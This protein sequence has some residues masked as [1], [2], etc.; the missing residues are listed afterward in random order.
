MNVKYLGKFQFS[1]TFLII[2]NEGSHWRGDC[3]GASTETCPHEAEDQHHRLAQQGG[4]GSGSACLLSC[5]KYDYFLFSWLQRSRKCSPQQLS[6]GRSS[7]D[8]WRSSTWPTCQSPQPGRWVLWWLLT[9]KQ[10]ANSFI[11]LNLDGNGNYGD[12]NGRSGHVKGLWL[13]K[14]GE[15]YAYL[16]KITDNHSLQ[17]WSNGQT[18]A[19]CNSRPS[20]L[21]GICK[22]TNKISRWCHFA[23]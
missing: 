13:L 9:T 8:W 12:N 1:V 18:V 11:S 5:P 23:F 7:P 10:I 17:C 20:L 15:K 3:A 19:V 4:S 2:I 6:Q 16:I 21:L 14:V 22:K